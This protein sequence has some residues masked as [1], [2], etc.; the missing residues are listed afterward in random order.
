MPKT[1]ALHDNVNAIDKG[2]SYPAKII[3]IYSA[4]KNTRYYIH[5]MGWHAKYDVWVDE[6]LISFPIEGTRIPKVGRSSLKNSKHLNKAEIFEVTETTNNKE[7][8]SPSPNKSN[9]KN[10]SSVNLHNDTHYVLVTRTFFSFYDAC[11]KRSGT[12]KKAM[13]SYFAPIISLKL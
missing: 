4:G 13:K 6:K 7:V 9:K 11:S 8:V 12:L 10:R 2:K 1:F 5:F 3:N